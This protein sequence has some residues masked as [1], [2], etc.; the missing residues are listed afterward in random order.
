MKDAHFRSTSVLAVVV[1]FEIRSK[2]FSNKFSVCYIIPF[3]RDDLHG[4][5][6]GSM[7]RVLRKQHSSSLQN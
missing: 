1:S 7:L 3:L 2:I 6:C 4:L 5:D